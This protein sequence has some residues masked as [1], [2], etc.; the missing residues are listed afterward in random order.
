MTFIHSCSIVKTDYLYQFKDYDFKRMFLLRIGNRT[1]KKFGGEKHPSH[2]DI[3][4][5][6]FKIKWYLK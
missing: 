5:R 2:Y 1:F 3:F 4:K 6:R